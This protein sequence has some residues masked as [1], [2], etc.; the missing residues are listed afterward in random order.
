MSS[1]RILI[2]E[3]E[4]HLATGIRFNLEMEGYDAE[5]AADG[6]E[7]LLRVSAPPVPFDLVILDVMLPGMDGFELADRM[8]KAGD[9]TPILMLTAKGQPE[10]VVHGLEVGADDYLPKPF[11]L[12]VLLARVKGLL[13][14]RGWARGEGASEPAAESARVGE[15]EVDFKSFEIR[16]RGTT[17]RLTPLEAMLLRHL[18]QNAGRVVSKSE[19]L[20]KV[21]NPGGGQL[22]RA[23]P[24]AYRA[25][26]PVPPASPYRPRRG[27]PSGAVGATRGIAPRARM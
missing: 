8:R 3:D 26:P 2:V 7:A 24:P 16:A 15:A 27:I 10:D 21:W 5:V 23:P 18:V 6:Q 14:R 22:H 17:S 1:A 13:R 9:Y 4:A 12:A 20:E 11:D 19:I 25:Q